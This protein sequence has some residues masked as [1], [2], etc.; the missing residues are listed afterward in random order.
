[1]EAKRLQARLDIICANIVACEELMSHFAAIC[2]EPNPNFQAVVENRDY[3][4]DIRR[5]LDD[6]HDSLNSLASILRGGDT[7][8]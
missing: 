5:V 2:N 8:T 6:V 1:M 4:K 7:P 3:V